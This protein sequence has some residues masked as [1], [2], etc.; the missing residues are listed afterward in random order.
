MAFVPVAG[1]A[2]EPSHEIGMV[3]YDN[4]VGDDLMLEFGAFAVRARL[5]RLEMGERPSCGT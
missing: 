2:A 4:G 5:I 3:M 1:R